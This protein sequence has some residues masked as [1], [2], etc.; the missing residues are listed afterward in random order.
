MREKMK[1]LKDKPILYSTPMVQAV[2]ADSKTHTRRIMKPQ[3]QSKSAAEAYLAHCPYGQT[4]TTLWVRE[5]WRIQKY[6]FADADR[7]KSEYQYRADFSE[8]TQNSVQWKPS[9][10]MPREACRIFLK[11]ISIKVEKLQEITE[12]DARK[13]GVTGENARDEFQK[14]WGNINGPE[15]WDCNPWVWVVHFTREGMQTGAV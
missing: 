7:N 15:S 4:G 2:L 1:K 3:P 6:S 10:F 9:I 13:E 11:V 5:T 8:E 14:L 12:E